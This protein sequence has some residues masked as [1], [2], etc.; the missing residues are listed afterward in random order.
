MGQPCTQNCPLRLLM[1]VELDW[2]ALLMKWGRARSGEF[3]EDHQDGLT[4]I[5]DSWMPT[6][7]PLH[8]LLSV[9]ALGARA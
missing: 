6:K 3:H 2:A 1:T 8:P 7:C 4:S 9:L 5:L